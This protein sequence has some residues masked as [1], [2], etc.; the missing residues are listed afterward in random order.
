MLSQNRKKKS[1]IN[2][3]DQQITDQ[4]IF[5][6]NDLFLEKFAWDFC[7]CRLINPSCSTMNLCWPAIGRGCGAFFSANL[8]DF[9]GSWP[10]FLSAGLSLRSYQTGKEIAEL[11]VGLFTRKSKEI[12]KLRESYILSSKRNFSL[13]RKKIRP[14]TIN[15]F[16]NNDR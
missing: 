7:N 2:K 4:S 16:S 9:A 1:I 3:I 10:I 6:G 11:D 14:K 8:W 12:W 5:I 13:L 15:L